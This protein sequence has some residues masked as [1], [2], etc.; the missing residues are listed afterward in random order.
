MSDT[1]GHR[2][3]RLAFA[4]RGSK[5]DFEEEHKIAAGYLSRIQSGERSPG[6]RVALI[7]ERALGIPPEAWDKPLIDDSDTE[8][9]P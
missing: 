9:S 3:F 6:R 2:L 1:E 4:Q 5:A 8:V 7:L